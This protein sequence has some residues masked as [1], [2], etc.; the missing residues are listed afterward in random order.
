MREL[1]DGVIEAR[2]V[3]C[4]AKCHKGSVGFGRIWDLKGKWSHF[5]YPFR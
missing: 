1:R 5:G 3:G 4:D 2:N